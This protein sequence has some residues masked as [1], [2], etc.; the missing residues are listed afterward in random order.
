MGP[1]PMHAPLPNRCSPGVVI[2]VD[3]VTHIV[4]IVGPTSTVNLRS[5]FGCGNRVGANL[6]D[7]G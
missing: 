1:T 5:S 4:R 2:R 7:C 3:Q 6:K